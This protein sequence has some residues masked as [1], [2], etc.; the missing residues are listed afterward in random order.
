MKKRSI[1]EIILYLIVGLL[2]LMGYYFLMT[3]YFK[4]NPFEGY[5]W[6]PTIYLIVCY[7]LF[8][9][10]GMKLSESIVDKLSDRLLMPQTKMILA[11]LFAPFIVIFKKNK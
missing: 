11:F 3:E 5:Y 7:F 6:I 10:S 1:T 8:P 9:I 2:P 4:I